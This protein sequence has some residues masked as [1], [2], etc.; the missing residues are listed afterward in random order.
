MLVVSLLTL[1]ILLITSRIAPRETKNDRVLLR[2]LLGGLTAFSIVIVLAALKRVDTYEH[3]F[4]YTRLRVAVA[5]IELWF[6]LLFVLILIAGITLRAG[7]SSA[8]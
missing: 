2:V 5:G 1:T 6:G 4:G 8:G 3:L 7:W